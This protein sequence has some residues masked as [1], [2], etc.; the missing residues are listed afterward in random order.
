MDILSE[1]LDKSE[2]HK[3][4]AAS[5]IEI[6]D[7]VRSTLGP[8]GMNKML[9]DANGNVV[10]TNDGVTILQ[11]MAIEDPI[12]DVLR[13]LANKQVQECSDGTTT[14]ILFAGELLTCAVDLF[15][16]GYHPTTITDGYDHANRIAKQEIVNM[17]VPFNV[18]DAKA[19]KHI[20]YSAV[21]GRGVGSV[22]EDGLAEAAVETIR[23]VTDNGH[24][25]LDL[26]KVDKSVGETA[27]ALRIHEGA[28]IEENPAHPK[29]P[30]D[31]RDANVLLV[32]GPLQLPESTMD[33]E[34][35]ISVDD[36]TQLHPFH[37]KKTKRSKSVTEHIRGLGANVVFFVESSDDELARQLSKRDIFACKVARPKLTFLQSVVNASPIPDVTRATVEEIG[38][39]D[40]LYDDSNDWFTVCGD[41]TPGVTVSIRGAVKQVVDELHR[42]LTDATD[43]IGAAVDDGYVLVGGGATEVE[44]AQRLR[45]QATTISDRRQIAI[46]SFADALE[47]V[48]K[49]LA[50]NAGADAVDTLIELRNEHANGN[51]YAGVGATGEVIRDMRKEGI[52][53]PVTVKAK[54]IDLATEAASLITRIDG[55][56]PAA[57]NQ[58]RDRSN[59]GIE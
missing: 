23:G 55:T 1:N 41:E 14:T 8:F 34:A 31:I 24:V 37:D 36:P 38:R 11:E 39:G 28:L 20:A 15:D 5:A 3:R 45:F 35:I 58:R 7:M 56:I 49:Q 52:V 6:A 22:A 47:V 26:V 32:D 4:T 48:P 53:E 2:V 17:A 40:V 13:S 12:A 46:E 44:L 51:Q 27:L 43:A 16:Q 18:T 30:T 10:V 33:E 25:D 57:R 50:R 21:N 54:A 29:M 42:G 59:N 9:I 19:A